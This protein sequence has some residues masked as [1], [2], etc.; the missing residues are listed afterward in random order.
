MR[1]QNGIRIFTMKFYIM[2]I[3]DPYSLFLKLR[4]E[5]NKIRKTTHV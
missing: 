5:K 1:Q 4:G 3:F 2:D